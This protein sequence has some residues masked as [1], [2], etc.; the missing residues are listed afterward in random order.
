MQFLSRPFRLPPLIERA[1]CKIEVAAVCGPALEYPV[2]HFVFDLLV[3][4]VHQ[5][6][7]KA[8][9][10]PDFPNRPF[11]PTCHPF[12]YGGGPVFKQQLMQVDLHG[13]H[14]R[15]VS[16]KRGCIAEV[17]PVVHGPKVGSDH[18]ADRSAV[19]GLIRMSTDV[20]VY[21][22]GIQAGTATDAVKALP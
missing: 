18:R 17:L 9:L 5:V 8:D 14:F 21:G 2:H 19:G 20:L 22:A 6:T 11:R 16:A 7:V 1:G 13:T 15:T 3:T 4:L 12:F 10:F